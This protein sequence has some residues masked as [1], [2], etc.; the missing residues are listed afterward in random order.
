M[1]TPRNDD[2]PP[3][4]GQLLFLAIALLLSFGLLTLAAGLGPLAAAGA[5]L[6]VAGLGFIAVRDRERPIRPRARVGRAGPWPDQGLKAVTG[7]LGAAAVLTDGRGV[8]RYLNDEAMALFPHLT[9]GEPLAL[10]LRVPVILEALDRVMAGETALR[11]AWSQRVPTEQWFEARIAPIAYPPRPDGARAARP[12]FILVTIED[13]SERHRLERMRADFVANASHEMRTPLAAV[14]GF[15]ETLQGPAKD[16]A[17]ARER[18]LAIMSDQ[19]RRMR[20]LIDDLLSLSRI[21]MRAHLRPSETVDLAEILGRVASSLA[22]IARDSDVTIDLDLKE[23]PLKVRG[24]ADELAQVFSNLI[25]NAIKYGGS[26]KTVTVRATRPEPSAI[27]VSVIDQGP[28]IAAEH[29]PRLTE[30]FYR[31]DVATSRSK[32]GTGLGLA[33]VKHIVTRHRARLAIA[34]TLG[35]GATFA[36]TFTAE[37]N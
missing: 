18:F 30:R 2:A 33:I 7:A 17:V 20:R 31:V 19:A 24:D 10:G 35:E 11:V 34:S 14:S 1:D 32:Q 6:P 27:C 3:A 28:G 29:L 23:P 37:P 4:A 9:P 21:E 16:D 8:V 13:L 15:I 12:D 5:L 25:E 26:G 36:V 22:P